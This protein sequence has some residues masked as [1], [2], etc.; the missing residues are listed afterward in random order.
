MRVS[1]APLASG[2]VVRW[3]VGLVVVDYR[4]VVLG[5]SVVVEEV[6]LGC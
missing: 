2:S 6:V 1:L 4:R 3:V 5:E